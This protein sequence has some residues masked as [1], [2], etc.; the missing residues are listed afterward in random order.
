MKKAAQGFTLTELLVVLAIVVIFVAI[1][2][3]VI[4][5]FEVM[6]KGRDSTR[7]SDLDNLQKAII[8]ALSNSTDTAATLC[9]NSAVPCTDSSLS[10]GAR[11]N[12]STGW[13]KVDFTGQLT[14]SISTLPVDPIN[15]PTYH[16]TYYSDGVSF[17]LNAVLESSK[18]RF[19]MAQDG[20]DNNNVYEVGTDL[21][22]LH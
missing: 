16:Y 4:N 6:K 13:V 12:D 7:M 5:P 2:L 3:V 9:H 18:Q 21:A 17:E 14:L 1:V 19:T 8:V 15:N 20:G 22:L 11:N 10:L